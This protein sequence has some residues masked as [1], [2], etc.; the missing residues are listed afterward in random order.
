MF[1]FVG[2]PRI[3]GESGESYYALRMPRF[4]NVLPPGESKWFNWL[5]R[6]LRI[7]LLILLMLGA[8][9]IE[10]SLGMHSVHQ[11]RPIVLNTVQITA[12][13]SFL[14][15]GACLVIFGGL[16]AVFMRWAKSSKVGPL[17]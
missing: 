4:N 12:V 6:K 14:W 17:D 9:A 16:F 3:V 11:D 7:F 2:S 15:C 10:F 8:A 5:P 1:V 13:E